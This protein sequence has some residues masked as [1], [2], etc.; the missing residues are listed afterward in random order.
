MDSIILCK[1]G[2]GWYSRGGCVFGGISYRNLSLPMG[3]VS[4]LGTAVGSR[5]GAHFEGFWT[6]KMRDF[7][8]LIDYGDVHRVNTQVKMG[9]KW[10]P[11]GHYDPLNTI[12]IRAR[13]Y[14]DC[15]KDAV[16]LKTASNSVSGPQNG[17]ILGSRD[18]A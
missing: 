14:N 6:A 15:V 18:G 9:P 12:P 2:L 1:Y 8:Y 17:P 4:G 5:I 7:G 11:F 3:L 10:G 13:A 16:L